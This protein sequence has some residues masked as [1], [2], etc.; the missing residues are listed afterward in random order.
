MYQAT[1]DVYYLKYITNNV[2]TIGGAGWAIKEFSW[3]VKYVGLQV[4]AA[5]VLQEFSTLHKKFR[6]I[7][8]DCLI[9]FIVYMLQFT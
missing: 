6:C 8:Y 1:G 3:D 2:E 4:L 7:E 5:K 9:G